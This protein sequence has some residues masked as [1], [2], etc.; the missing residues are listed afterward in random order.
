MVTATRP[1]AA[2][3][4]SELNV[5]LEILSLWQQLKQPA[6]EEKVVSQWAEYG[7]RGGLQTLQNHGRQH[8]SKISCNGGRPK[9]GGKI[10]LS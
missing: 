8:F 4:D 10:I 9:G 2:T 7:R 6:N 5:L 1:I 3:E